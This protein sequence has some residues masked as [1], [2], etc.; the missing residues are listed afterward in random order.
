M[1]RD[2]ELPSIGFLSTY[3]PTQCGLATFTAALRGAI[4][5]TRGSDEG[6]G[7]VSL[8]DERL[9]K[10]RPEVVYEHLNGDH[11]SL[12]SAIEALNSFDVAFVQHEYG[13]YAGPDGSEVLDLLSGL[14]IPAIVTLH[15]VLGQPSPSQRSILENVIAL[16]ER[17]IVMSHT[18]GRRL[19]NG[20]QVDPA[21]VRMIPHGA[22]VNLSGPSLANGTRP[23][24]LTWGLIGPGKGL[25]TAIDAFASLQ[26]LRPL[27]R[28]VI[29]GEMHPKIRASQGDAYLKGLAARVHDLGLDDVVEFDTRYPDTD[30]LA[31]AVRQADLVVLPYE[32]TQQVT[33]GVLVEA[34]AAGKPV[35]ATAFPHAVELLADGAGIVVPHRDPIALTAALRKVLT[36]P[37]LAARMA[38]KARL[39]GSTLFWPTIAHQYD[40]LATKLA[41]RQRA[42]RTLTTAERPRETLNAPP[43]MVAASLGRLTSREHSLRPDPVPGRSLAGPLP[44]PRFE[45]LRRMTDRRGLWEHAR[46]TVPRT[47]HGYCTDD[48]ARALIVISR[49]PNPSRDLVELAKIYLAFLQHAQLPGGGFH[50][51]R[52]SNGSWADEV[53]SDD[54]QGRALWALGSVARSGPATW[55]REVGLAMFDRQRD[56]HSPFP[57]SN[58]FAILGAAEVLLSSPDHRHAR[59]I[60]EQCVDRLAVPDDARWPWPEERLTY[61]NAR[62][63]EALLAA[64]SLLPD[65]GLVD[66]GLHLLEW[67]VSTET[68]DG[69]FSFTP[70]GGW[71]PDEPRPG[72]DQQPLEAAAMADA[73]SR[74]WSLTGDSRWKERV[75]RAARWFVGA[76]DTGAVL[77]DPQ[78]GG[79]GDGLGPD[80]INLNQGAES[81]L[82]ALAA[83]QQAEMLG[84]LK[85]AGCTMRDL[86]AP[87]A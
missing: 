50:N 74:A 60:L 2:R 40:R 43:R 5:D 3:P 34:I 41:A 10:A 53:G 29:L 33:S 31:L 54:S 61:D 67:L 86:I 24:V 13:I 27:P 68:L 83:L 49:R 62:I 4:A 42:T 65:E 35:V 85:C 64:G 26:D 79:C 23:V 48:N 45:H 72:F 16:T 12:R 57:R 63:P 56:F 18:A 59:H 1:R 19:V 39:I 46:Y 80:H 28:Y 25:E 44:A 14:E 73:C 75:E 6:L 66:A 22:A 11:T 51:R 55:M 87:V 9:D 36:H 82:A 58:S 7:V 15:T 8:V 32:S 76:N 37:S 71:A 69:H 78:T 70:V 52:R 77:Y 81:T 47:E 20:Y 38:R 21:K 30:T 17:T 84:G